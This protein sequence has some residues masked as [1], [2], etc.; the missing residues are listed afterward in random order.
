MSG[1]LGVSLIVLAL[2]SSACLVVGDDDDP[3]GGTPSNGGSPSNGGTPN[4]GGSPSDGG[5]GGAPALGGGGS[6]GN[7]GGGPECQVPTDCPEPEFYCTDLTCAE[8]VCGEE[9]SDEGT[10]CGDR[11]DYFCDA[12]GFCVECL[13]DNDCPGSEVCDV[14]TG[15]CFNENATGACA[16]TFCSG[17]PANGTCA[18][19]LQVENQTSCNPEFL[20]CNATGANASCTTCLE[21]LQ[22]E[23]GTFCAGS[24]SAYDDYT[25]CICS[26]GNCLD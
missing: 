20:A 16:S 24:Q 25:D 22:G 2:S 14:K 10:A 26:S 18:T 23:S 3:V 11:G 15:T 9:F 21:R 4:V 17:L 5:A 8:G 12:E 6:T 1:R 7:Q 19:C 13:D